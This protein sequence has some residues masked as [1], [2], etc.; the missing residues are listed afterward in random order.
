M[1]KKTRKVKHHTTATVEQT[2]QDILSDAG[3]TFAVVPLLVYEDS[4]GP[5]MLYPTVKE[6][7]EEADIVYPDDAIIE[8]MEVGKLYNWGIA[9]LYEDFHAFCWIVKVAVDFKRLFTTDDEPDNEHAA[10]LVI[11]HDKLLEWTRTEP[12]ET[13]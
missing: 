7:M 5:V 1:T 6:L 8:N 3:F 13:I 9:N 4:V 12:K 10:C 11:P 2:V